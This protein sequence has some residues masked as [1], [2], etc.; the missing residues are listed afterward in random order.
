ML[1]T[2]HESS[3][4]WSIRQE[5]FLNLNF[6]NL[7]VH[8]LCNKS[9][10][11]EQYWKGTTRDHSSWVWSNF[12]ER[13]KIRSRLKFCLYNL[14]SNCDPRCRVIFYPKGILW[15]ILVEYHYIMLYTKHESSGPC[16]FWHDQFFKLHFKTYFLTPWPT[17]ATN[18]NGLNNFDKGTPRDHS[19]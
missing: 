10:P 1:Y 16:I 12:Q 17:Y 14:L 8:T 19:C 3:G 2:K 5:Y 15:T 13:F 11:I 6:E 18:W 9:E 7:F 4:S